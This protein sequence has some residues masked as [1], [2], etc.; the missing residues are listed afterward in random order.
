[1]KKNLECLANRHYFGRRDKFIKFVRYEKVGKRF[2]VFCPKCRDWFWATEQ[3][4]NEFIR[5]V[6]Y[7]DL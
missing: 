2:Y 7:R 4:V 1:M 6:S 5:G 3:E